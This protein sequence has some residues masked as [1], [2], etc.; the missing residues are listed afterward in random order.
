MNIF[1]AAERYREEKC[2]LIVIAGE[3]YAQ[4]LCVIGK[5]KDLGNLDG[6]L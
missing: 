1:D 4:A 2:N 3:E 5:Q 6:I